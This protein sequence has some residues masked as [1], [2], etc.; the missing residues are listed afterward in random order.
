MNLIL[1]L[2]HSILI[3]ITIQHDYKLIFAVVGDTLTFWKKFRH[4][5]VTKPHWHYYKPVVQ[6]VS[7][8]T[9]MAFQ[10]LHSLLFLAFFRL[11]RGE[12][13]YEGSEQFKTHTSQLT[14]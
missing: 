7:K 14:I 12:N 2:E 5:F 9:V 4:L 11:C 13:R 1:L 6:T 8:T 10:T 3:E